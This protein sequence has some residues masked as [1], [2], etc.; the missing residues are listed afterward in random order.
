MEKT[1]VEKKQQVRGVLFD[2]LE[3][4]KMSIDEV[5][6]LAELNKPLDQQTYQLRYRD[7]NDGQFFDAKIHSLRKHPEDG[8]FF[9]VKSD[10]ERLDLTSLYKNRYGDSWYIVVTG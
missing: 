9:T 10:S 3:K 2:Y 5:E 6:S 8:T 4:D 1:D 7:I